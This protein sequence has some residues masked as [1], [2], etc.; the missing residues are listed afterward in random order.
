[1]VAVIEIIVLVVLLA[2]VGGRLL[3]VRLPLART[4]LAGLAGVAAGVVFGYL[5]WRRDHDQVTLPVVGAGVLAAVV[6]MMLVMVLAELLARPSRRD[7]VPSGMPHPW[8]A[9]RRMAQ[10]TRRSAQLTKIAARHGLASPAVGRADPGQLARRLRP[11]LEE[12]GPIFVKLGQVLSTR[13]DLLPLPVTTEL[14]KLQ[15]QVPP[16]PWPQI[17]ALLSE[18]LGGDP[19]EVFKSVDPEPLASASLAQAHAAWRADGTAVILKI[20]RPG[21]DEQVSRDLDMIRRLTRRAESRSEL[22]RAYHLA[23][24]ARGFA[25]ALAEELDFRI[26]ARNIA[27]IAA[28][29]PPDATVLIPAVHTDISSRR[30]LVLERFDGVSVRDAGPELD[31]LGADRPAL[32]RGLLR[33]L[34]RQILLQGTFHAD[35]H[36]GNVLVL[37]SGQLALIDF[38]SAGRLDIGQ[39]AAL[40]RLFAATGQRDPAELYD[41]VTELAVTHPADEEALEETLAAFMTRY[42]GPGMTVDA[43]LIRNLLAVLATAGIAFPPVIGGVFRTLTVLDGTLRTLAPASTSPP[44]PR[45]WPASSPGTSSPRPRCATP[46]PANCSPCCRCCASCRAAPTR[47]PPR[48]PR[49]GSPANLRLF[50][51]PHDVSVITTLV[52]RAVLG[53]L[54]AALG[55]ISVILLLAPRSP[56]ITTGLT[57]LQLLG[58]TGLFLAITLILRVVLEIISPRRRR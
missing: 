55:V 14:A 43:A 39:Q 51:D 1:M 29:A 32:A 22:A 50:S 45:P 56:R 31:K 11:A 49:G 46:P 36:P 18:E 48:S 42:L 33:D 24:L 10:N 15:D 9:L 3:G 23:D 17:Q 7:L 21:I 4:V 5:V 6:A 41:A 25:D 57:L 47:S 20:Q 44:N 40:Q 30:L 12:A 27:V 38:G 16:A 28:A 2:A 35:P 54:G 19:G 26:E 34:L 37:R 53:L 52:N 13:T 58:Y 8:R